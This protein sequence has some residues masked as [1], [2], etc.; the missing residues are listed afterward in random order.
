MVMESNDLL[1]KIKKIN[2]INSQEISNKFT[3]KLESYNFDIAYSRISNLIIIIEFLEEFLG[4]EEIL[5]L[6]KSICNI[7]TQKELQEISNNVS[8]KVYSYLKNLLPTS[9]L[10]NLS[11]AIGNFIIK[12]KIKMRIIKLYQRI[13]QTILFLIFGLLSVWKKKIY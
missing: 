4:L 3:L 9:H 11:L 5:S 2:F 12:K 7:S 10:Q 13:F 6:D 1:K 8:K